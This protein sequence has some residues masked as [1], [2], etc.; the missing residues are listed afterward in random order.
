MNAPRSLYRLLFSVAVVA[1]VTCSRAETADPADQVIALTPAERSDFARLRAFLIDGVRSS[2]AR[3]RGLAGYNQQFFD[4]D[5]LPAAQRVS[6]DTLAD[7]ARG[8][9]DPIV[10][11]LL[12]GMC[13][14]DRLKPRPTCDARAIAQQWTV[15]DTQNQVAWLTLASVLRWS[16]DEAGSRAAFERG[17]RASTWHESYDEGTRVIAAAMPKGLGPRARMALLQQA[18]GASAAWL[19]PSAAISELNFRCKDDSLRVACARVIDTID[20]DGGS[21][22]S[23]QLAASMG[24][25]SGFDPE[26]MTRRTR[27]LD[28]LTY[29][30]IHSGFKGYDEIVDPT[31]LDRQADQ[32]DRRVALGEMAWLRE[33]LDAQRPARQLEIDAYVRERERGRERAAA[34]ERQRAAKR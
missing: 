3:V 32:L 17:A 16:G 26:T 28:T 18:L 13:G 23:R 27:T 19:T 1:V 20:G 7:L 15:A 4:E 12:V 24:R 30:S 33:L 9:T 10:L 34:D 31:E 5:T 8:S 11:S 2:D 14:N 21:M 29:A 22:M 25:R 6:V